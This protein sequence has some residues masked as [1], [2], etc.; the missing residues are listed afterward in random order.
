MNGS[1][2]PPELTN[3]A[4]YYLIVLDD[5]RFQLSEYFYETITSDKDVQVIDIS[6]QFAATISRINPELNAYRTLQ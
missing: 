2:L 6:A 1:S 4:I 3:G 5:H